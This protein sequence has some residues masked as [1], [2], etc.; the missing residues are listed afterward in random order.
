[1]KRL[2]ALLFALL[3]CA[4]SS[5][6]PIPSGGWTFAIMGDT[7]YDAREEA[8]LG[9]MIGQM[10][11]E[12]LAFVV[13]VG[14][15]ISGRG[16]C[17]DAVLAQ[18][19]AVFAQFAHPFVL[20]PGDNDW[21]DCH[22]GGYDPL[23]R[24]D[25]FRS[26]FHGDKDSL[27]GRTM[28]LVR[29]G[30]LDPRYKEYREHVRWQWN[31]VLFVGLNVQGSNNNLGRTAQMDAEYRR[32]MDATFEWLD[33]A[34]KKAIDT[35]KTVK[36]LEDLLKKNPEKEQNEAIKKAIELKKIADEQTKRI[37]ELNKRKE[38]T[39]TVVA[40]FKALPTGEK[41]ADE[42][43]TKKTE[44]TDLIETA[45][46]QGMALWKKLSIGGGIGLGAIAG[47][48]VLI[49]GIFEELSDASEGAA[50]FVDDFKKQWHMDGDS[51]DTPSNATTIPNP[52]PKADPNDPN[53]AQTLADIAAL[54]TDFDKDL[55]KMLAKNSA[56]ASSVIKFKAG[57]VDVDGT[58]VE[59][60]IKY[61]TETLDVGIPLVP[62]LITTSP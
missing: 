38:D 48:G 30:D 37:E 12:N 16:N 55:A 35:A 61:D 13:H 39:K 27:G 26:L 44:P 54:F 9:P 5:Q 31:G 52:L 32:R 45:K 50:E 3:L 34:V 19:K 40:K 25:K 14:D 2:S 6:P 58:N 11:N 43:A 59:I 53:Y 20:L 42:E 28:P 46:T 29:Q 23:E 51:E 8:L 49:A 57:E 7:P 33:E 36:D 60:N 62:V 17:S 10:N 15:I 18:R 21:T 4:C 22:R 41:L 1:M 24:L 56:Y 47:V